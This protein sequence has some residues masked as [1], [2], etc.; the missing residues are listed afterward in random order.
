MRTL[1]PI[2]PKTLGVPPTA[3]PFS[4]SRRNARAENGTTVPGFE[5]LA[6]RG[7][8]VAHPVVV[9]GC[10]HKL[11]RRLTTEKPR[12]PSSLFQNVPSFSRMWLVGGPGLIPPNKCQCRGRES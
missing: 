3:F 9:D 4:G 11:C 8:L 1:Q 7:S 6:S 2:P 10:R 12:I 5:S